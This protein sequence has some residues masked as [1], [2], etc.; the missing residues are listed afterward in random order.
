MDKVNH[1]EIPAKNLKKNGK[2]YKKV[3]DWK[4]IE[5]PG[6]PEY[7]IIHTTPVDDKQMVK[8]KGAINGGMFLKEEGDDRPVM[9][10]ATVES[11]DRTIKKVKENG[12]AVT[13]EK[14]PI[15]KMGF[16]AYIRD[17]E[18]N[19]M[20]LFEYAKNNDVESISDGF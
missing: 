8:E 13:Q 15:M 5:V 19:M 2:F 20:G 7:Q 12:G 6:M 4:I 16:I 3:F 18:G 9:I 17:P 10:T 1:F 14:T 11:I